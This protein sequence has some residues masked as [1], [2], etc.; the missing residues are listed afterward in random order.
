MFNNRLNA[1]QRLHVL[2]AA[3]FSSGYGNRSGEFGYLS[4]SSA[5]A[6]ASLWCVPPQKLRLCAPV[7]LQLEFQVRIWLS[8]LDALMRVLK[9][10][11]GRGS[12]G[13]TVETAS[14]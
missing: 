14:H 5:P 11:S 1:P 2:V 8:Q 7:G 9:F 3:M 4:V 12:W 10:R 13:D 6:V